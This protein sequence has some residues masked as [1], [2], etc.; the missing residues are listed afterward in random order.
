MH[1]AIVR[2]IVPPRRFRLDSVA[3]ILPRFTI[4]IYNLFVDADMSTNQ[5]NPYR[6]RLV[7]KGLV[8]GSTHGYVS[9]TLPLFERYVVEHS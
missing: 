6:D 5:F 1:V 3:G 9:F 8:D 2:R 7:K 4:R